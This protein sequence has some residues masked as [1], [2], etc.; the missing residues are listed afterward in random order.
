MKRTFTTI[1][2][3][4]A[5]GVLFW[6]FPLFHV[7]PATGEW[8]S[9]RIAEF[10]AAKFAKSF[11]A[12]RLVPAFNQAANAASVLAAFEE[13]YPEAREQ[14]G[15]SAGLG[16]A[17][18]YLVGGTGT[19]VAVDERGVGIAVRGG[20]NEPEVLLQTGLVSGNAVR[21]ATGLISAS[22]Y[23]SSQEFNAI[24]IQ[25]NRIVEE[26]VIPSLKEKAKVGGKVTFVGC[27]RVLNLPVDVKPLKIVPLEVRFE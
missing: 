6:F 5:A 17:A 13:N 7:V 22:D 18:I 11:W 14:Y 10:D 8:G 3:L 23:P 27:G 2:F 15:R 20:G 26:S 25:L 4:L 19:I 21:D 12:K 24:S 9:E 16:R 1:G